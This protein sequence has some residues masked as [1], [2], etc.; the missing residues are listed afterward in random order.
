MQDS[1]SG[2]SAEEGAQG[3]SF[4]ISAGAVSS[5]HTDRN[6]KKKIRVLI[7]YLLLFSCFHLLQSPWFSY[8]PF[9]FIVPIVVYPENDLALP[10]RFLVILLAGSIGIY[11]LFRWSH[12]SLFVGAF[13]AAAISSVAA[14]GMYL[15][16]YTLH[17]IQFRV[18]FVLLLAA[19][20]VFA[21]VSFC[22]SVHN[23]DA[24]SFLGSCL[25]VASLHGADLG[26]CC[27]RMAP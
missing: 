6:G 7:L 16:C 13:G 4:Q 26:R 19:I 8:E 9:I 18:A 1:D 17:N 23:G 12:P 11:D 27:S 21:I 3:G 25:S 10:F 2:C 14:V 20:V 5:V 22:M 15:L 24:W